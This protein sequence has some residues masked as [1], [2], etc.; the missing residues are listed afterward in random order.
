M[1]EPFGLYIHVPFCSTRCGY[2][3]FNTYTPGELGSP[4]DLTGPYLA[5]LDQEL[6]MAA[7]RVGRTADTVFIGG[8][9]P[10][11]L[12]S[13]GL[14]RILATVRSTFG[15]SPGAEVTTESNPESTS[16][17][18]FAMLADAGFN[19]IS[20]G[21]QSASSS[22]LQVLERAH[23]P[24]RAFDAARE[25]RAAGFQHVNLDMI[26]GTPTET[27]DNVRETLDRVLET[28]VDHVSAYSLIVEDG[29]RMARKVTKGLLPAPDEDVLARRYEMIST[30]LEDAGFEWYEVSNWSLPGGECEHNRI[31]WVDGNWWGAGP[32]AHSHLGDQRFYNVKHPNRYI[33]TIEKGELPIKDSETLTGADRHME[34]VML[35]LRLREGIPESW[36]DAHATAALEDLIDRGLIERAGQRVRVTKPGRLLADGI[37]SDL[38]I[39]EES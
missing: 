18:Y 5:A 4:R 32:G 33:Q 15:L 38:L 8:G 14:S 36:L 13:S 17:E 26:Y 39:A 25:A 3:D 11:L 37:V 20:L 27:D 30:T 9:T 22:V 19:R 2:C 35:G 7:N 16:P 31:Y 1:T 12:G 34:K 6:E 24:G 28:G 21:M 23:T 29:T 10:S